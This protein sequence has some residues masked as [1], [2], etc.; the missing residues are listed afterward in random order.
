MNTV[1]VWLLIAT[2]SV[3]GPRPPTFT[4]VE[5]FATP[6][7]CG[8]VI[9]SIRSQAKSIAAEQFEYRCI[10]ATVLKPQ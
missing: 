9:T 3:G 7:D 6:Q 4:V 2:S 8:A 5:R 10:V 1:I